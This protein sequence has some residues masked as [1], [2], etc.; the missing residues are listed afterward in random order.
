VDRLVALQ[1]A[2]DRTAKV[3]RHY[4]PAEKCW[5][6]HA[7]DLAIGGDYSR[8]GWTTGALQRSIVAVAERHAG[9]CGSGQ[10]GTCAEIR[11]ALATCLSALAWMQDDELEHRY[12]QG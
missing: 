7:G 11:E 5:E 6:M 1:D 3:A 8:T 4:Q 9:E 10:C 12:S 2:I